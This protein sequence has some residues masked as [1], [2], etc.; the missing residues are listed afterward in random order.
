MVSLEVF[1]DHT[2]RVRRQFAR[3]LQ[4]SPTAQLRLAQLQGNTIRRY[5]IRRTA[6]PDAALACRWMQRVGQPL[7]RSVTHSSVV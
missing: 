6:T 4:P 7:L 1:R 5:E 3:V 2:Q